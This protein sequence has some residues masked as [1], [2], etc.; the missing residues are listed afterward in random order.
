MSGP[1]TK[2]P[3]YQVPIVLAFLTAADD[4]GRNFTE[5]SGQH[6]VAVRVTSV[7]SLA[8]VAG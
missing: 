6:R 4:R 8:T 3:G 5:T 7:R 1:G 2:G